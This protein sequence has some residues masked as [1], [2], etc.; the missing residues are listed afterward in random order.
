MIDP[1]TGAEIVYG[2]GPGVAATPNEGPQYFRPQGRPDVFGSTPDVRSAFK[3]AG[4]HALHRALP[5]NPE[6]WRASRE[7]GPLDYMLPII[8]GL[9]AGA[10]GMKWLGLI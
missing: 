2:P 8:L 3:E 6:P 5:E 4:M 1:R 9:A 7:W 10:G